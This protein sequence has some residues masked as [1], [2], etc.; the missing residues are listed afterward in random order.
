MA[1]S[2]ESIRNKVKQ[3]TPKLTNT[4]SSYGDGSVYPHWNI[5][6][7]QHVK[8][9]FLPDADPTNEVFWREKQVIKLAFAGI[10]GDPNSKPTTVS[11][12]CIEMFAG[13]ENKCPILKVV[14]G[15]YKDGSGIEKSFANKYWKKKSYIFSG[16]VHENPLADPVPVNPIRR[17]V[18][19]P[20]IFNTVK[21]GLMDSELEQ[22]PT[23]YLRGL[24]FIVQKTNKGGYSDYTTSKYVRKESA[25][26]TDELSAI[27]QYGLLSLSAYLP[28]M[29]TDDELAIMVEM[30]NSS[31]DGEAYDAEKFGDYFRPVGYRGDD[32]DDNRGNKVEKESVA[33]A[34]IAT[35]EEAEARHAN[36]LAIIKAIQKDR[37]KG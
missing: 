10:K 16:F 29:P 17:F 15:W 23:D 7:G 24:D 32:E 25:L 22:L 31:V 33:K 9:R 6:E 30:F 3:D 36:S 26:T 13:Y 18:I 35:N 11:I 4:N 27:D 2:L 8:L 20:Q 34:P 19:S 5:D 12:P 14:R 37:I 21:A 1:I 28:K